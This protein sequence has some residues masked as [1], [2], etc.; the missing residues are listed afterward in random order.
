MGLLENLFGTN[1]QVK[2]QDDETGETKYFRDNEE[3]KKY[4]EE[5]EEEDSPKP[6]F[7]RVWPF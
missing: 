3:L 4:L 2:Y 5:K 7:E 1:P 6:F